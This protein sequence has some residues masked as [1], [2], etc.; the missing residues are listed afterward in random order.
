[1]AHDSNV[2]RSYRETLSLLYLAFVA[3]R[4]HCE[5]ILVLKV[6][7]NPSAKGEIKWYSK[8]DEFFSLF[9][10][11]FAWRVMAPKFAGWRVIEPKLSAWRGTGHHNVM[12]DLLFYKWVTRDLQDLLIRFLWLSNALWPR[13]I[14][15][16]HGSA[17]DRIQRDQKVS[18]SIEWKIWKVVDLNYPDGWNGN[19][20][21]S[22]GV[23]S[24]RPRKL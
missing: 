17:S 16:G 11:V 21:N 7:E 24:C 15:P 14:P 9:L 2:T 5:R 8:G 20:R 1:M 6:T 23:I 19:R 4:Y 12:C 18:E 13:R 3:L 22:F 10:I